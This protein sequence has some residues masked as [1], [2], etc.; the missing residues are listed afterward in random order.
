MRARGRASSSF[1]LPKMKADLPWTGGYTVQMMEAT[2]L[3]TRPSRAKTSK[4]SASP[5]DA[6]DPWSPCVIPMLAFLVL[7]ACDG[8]SESPV[9]PYLH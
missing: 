2:R 9:L 7:L 6:R 5:L 1:L 3:A 4:A 8:L